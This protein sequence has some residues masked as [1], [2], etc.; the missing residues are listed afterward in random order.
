MR[1]FMAILRGRGTSETQ[2]ISTIMNNFARQ[3][4][5]PIKLNPLRPFSHLSGSLWTINPYFGSSTPECYISFETSF[6]D[7]YKKIYSFFIIFILES[8]TLTEI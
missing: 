7:I 8:S 1:K 6:Q 2:E 5:A 3:P 4:I